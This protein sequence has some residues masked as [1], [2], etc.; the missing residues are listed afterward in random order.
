MF[1]DKHLSTFKQSLS[2][3]SFS[4]ENEWMMLMIVKNPRTFNHIEILKSTVSWVRDQLTHFQRPAQLRYEK[5][6]KTRPYA[7]R[8]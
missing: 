4:K 1:H 6:S 3:L 8:R 5:S 2:I 7:S